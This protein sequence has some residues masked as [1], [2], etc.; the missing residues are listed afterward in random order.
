M[1]LAH[2]L[3][4]AVLAA[5]VALLARAAF[6]D[7]P[8][9]TFLY[10]GFDPANPIPKVAPRCDTMFSVHACD[11]VHGR[12]DVPAGLLIAS[13][14]FAC[15]ETQFG[16]APSGLET[17]VEDDFR[18]AG[19]PPGTPVSFT[20]LL[21]LTGEGHNFSE[22]GG[23]GGARVRATVL[24]GA[25]NG[26]TFQRS[27]STG[28]TAPFFVDEALSLPVSATSGTPFHLRLAVRAESFDGRAQL[29]GRLEFA[30]MPPG[31]SVGSCRG[32]LSAAPVSA[33][34]S[35]WGRLKASYR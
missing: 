35:S 27:T 13:V 2:R 25:S 10:G 9:S 4:G 32:Y 30:G 18:L 1:R 24:E 16:A 12:F 31:V 6:A 26:A 19:V 14:D 20:V 22:P 11:G 7:C 17:V 15:N 28:S 5:G 21:H 23:P 8:Q 33:R 3:A 29:D 34:N